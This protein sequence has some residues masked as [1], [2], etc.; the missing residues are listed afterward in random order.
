MRYD[1][2]GFLDRVAEHAF[3]SRETEAAAA[4]RASARVM[5]RRVAAGELDK[6]R[7]VLPRD[8]SQF[9]APENLAEAPERRTPPEPRHGQD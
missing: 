2:D 6:V 7:M 5:S 9:L 3:L 1:L 4:V 8:I